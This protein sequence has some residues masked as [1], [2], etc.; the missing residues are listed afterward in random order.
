MKAVPPVAPSTTRTIG[1]VWLARDPEASP[2][3][4]LLEAAASL[5]LERAARR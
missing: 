4:A 3:R 2:A 5:D 1:L